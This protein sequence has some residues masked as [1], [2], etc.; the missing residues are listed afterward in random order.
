[1]H[2]P[3]CGCPSCY[4][5]TG[6]NMNNPMNHEYRYDPI[7]ERPAMTEFKAINQEKPDT[8]RGQILD[9]AKN[10][11]TGDR[12]KTYGPPI[13]NLTVYAELVSAYLIG[14]VKTSIDIKEALMNLDA[15][16]AAILMVLAK[17][18]RIAMNRG[19]K[20]NYVDGAAYM[21]IAGECDE[22]LGGK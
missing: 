8:L 4:M 20:D 17:V 6:P 10:L 16:D 12:D 11:T 1:M 3:E 5:K 15:V 2:K 21:A 9:T 14:K 18:S 19:H 13:D 7:K 22:L